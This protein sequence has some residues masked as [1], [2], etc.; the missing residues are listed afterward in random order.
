MTTAMRNSSE[1]FSDD[2]RFG[3]VSKGK[4]TPNGV[5]PRCA[6]EMSF[7]HLQQME[8]NYCKLGDDKIKRND[9]KEK[10][11]RFKVASLNGLNLDERI[12]LD[13]DSV[14]AGRRDVSDPNSIRE[15]QIVSSRGSIRGFKNRVR[16]GLA[17]FLDQY[18]ENSVNI[19]SLHPVLIATVP[20]FYFRFKRT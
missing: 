2:S 14:F 4:R 12:E 9:K 3:V 8:K 11:R 10:N 19:L 16:A 13:T 5:L 20:S 6:S 7:S 1:N 17:T 15:K 18:Q